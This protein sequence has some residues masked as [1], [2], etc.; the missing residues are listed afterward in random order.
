MPSIIRYGANDLMLARSLFPRVSAL[1]SGGAVNPLI[2][3]PWVAQWKFNNDGADSI[4]VNTLTNNGVATF[5]DGKLGGVTGATQLV[6]ASSQYWSIADNAALSMGDID[7][8]IAFWVK[9][10]TNPGVGNGI[11]WMAKEATAAQREFR[12]AL[13]YNANDMLIYA[14]VFN[15]NVSNAEVHSLSAVTVNAWHCVILWHDSVANVVGVALDGEENTGSYSGG[16]FDST[17]AFEIGRLLVITGQY[18][19]ANFDNVCIAKSAAGLGGVL[20]AAQR[21]AFYNGGVGTEN[22]T[23]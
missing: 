13:N 2:S 23:T 22:L 20:S 3:V 9:Q 15:S 10:R 7:F 16:S 6:A 19:N 8:T 4:G 21:T 12:I 1:A 5:T 14:Y 17:A 11:T 18:A